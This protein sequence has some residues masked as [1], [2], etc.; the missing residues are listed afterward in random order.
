M[1]F[2]SN[3]RQHVTPNPGILIIS[4]RSQ[5]IRTAIN[6]SHSGWRPPSAYHVYCIRHMASNFNLRFKSAE[7]KGYLVNVAYIPSNECCDWYLD[8]LGTLS[9]E[10]VDWALCFKKDLWLQHCDEDRR[11]G[12]MTTNLS[13][14]INVVLK[15]TGNLPVAAIVRATY[16]RLQQLFVCRGRETHAQLQGGQIYSQWLLTSI[17]KNRESL[18]MMRVTHCDRRESVFSVEELKPVDACVAASIEWGH[19]V[20]PVYTIV[21]I[22][23]V[24]ERE[25]LPIPDEKMWSPWYGACLKPNPAMRRKASGR[26]VSTRIRNE[27]DAVERV[28]KRCGL[29]HGEGHTIR[30]CPNAPQSDP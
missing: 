18:P 20:D 4:D 21:S 29:C 27:M 7:G 6:A 14:C 19:F 16:E 15:E 22:F 26:P 5:A 28:E 30:R 25:F 17:D 12:H 3:L 10:M 24:Y 11:Y 13:E 23:N 2:L 8:A 9:G 1:F